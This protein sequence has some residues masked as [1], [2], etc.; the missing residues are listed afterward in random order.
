LYLYGVAGSSS[1]AWH[2][3]AYLTRAHR[4]PG[5]AK[6]IAVLGANVLL[7]LAVVWLFLPRNYFSVGATSLPSPPS[8]PSQLPFW[9]WT[10]TTDTTDASAPAATAAGLVAAAALRAL[11]ELRLWAMRCGVILFQATAFDFT[12]YCGHR[13]MHVT[14]AGMYVHE[15][16]HSIKADRTWSGWRGLYK[17][18]P[19][20]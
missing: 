11:R 14:R 9:S 19:T 7:H 8:P 17:L 1:P 5:A 2:D 16:H 20:A 4:V 15:F 10:W 12:A 6:A 3:A 13:L 18:R